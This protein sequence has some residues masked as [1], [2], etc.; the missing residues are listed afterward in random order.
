MTVMY[1][2]YQVL[3]KVKFGPLSYLDRMDRIMPGKSK[4]LSIRQ[5]PFRRSKLDKI[6]FA[7]H[8]FQTLIINIPK[9]KI[10]MSDLVPFD[11]Q[12]EIIKKL[13]IKSVVRC[14]SVS[15]Q[16]KSLI[17]SSEFI[18]DNCLR[19]NQPHHLLVRYYLDS[20]QKYVSIID[21]DDSFPQH[22]M[23]P[24][25]TVALNQFQSKS[26]RI[27]VPNGI[28]KMHADIVIGFGVC[29]NTSDPKL[30]KI[31][32]IQSSVTGTVNCVPWEVEVFTLSSGFGEIDVGH[33]NKHSRLISFDLKHE[34]FGEVLL[35]DSLVRST[36]DM[37]LRKLMGSLAVIEGFYEPQDPFCVVWKM[38]EEGVL[39]SF[40]K[41]YT[42]K[43]YP[44]T[45][46]NSV[47]E[48]RKNG[49]P[50]MESIEQGGE[51]TIL[52][53]YGPCSGQVNDLWP[54]EN[55]GHLTECTA[56]S[57]TETLALLNQSDNIIY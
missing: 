48:F 54:D 15:K 33:E 36:A 55:H 20:V 27:V 45:I 5:S 42:F 12:T 43:A 21:D 4:L 51:L 35:S 25:V 24:T 14:R 46:M 56:Y 9:F 47:L 7:N 38:N 50:I 41:L 22:K 44:F 49:E 53:F 23:S 34:E 11:I 26:V 17:D 37:Y 30:V 31:K 16:W 29:P 39:K 10:S 57:Y 3:N 28:S 2:I 19:D 52:E 40:T 6:A 8:H 13:P 32:N 18:H 1:A